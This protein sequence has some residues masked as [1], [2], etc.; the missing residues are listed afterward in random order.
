MA[1]WRVVPIPAPADAADGQEFY[2]VLVGADYAGRVAS[3]PPGRGGGAPRW[4]AE[5][6]DG[7]R[8]GRWHPARAAAAAALADRHRAAGR[9]PGDAPRPH[10]SLYVTAAELAALQRLAAGLGYY[11]RRGPHAGGRGS[12]TALGAALASAAERDYPFALAVL[13]GL[14]GPPDGTEEGGD[15]A[16]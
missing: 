3:H 13:R 7:A 11:T 10:T 8:V 6:P 5:G 12:V 15:D 9:A 1:E 16:G 14:L 2:A 4:A